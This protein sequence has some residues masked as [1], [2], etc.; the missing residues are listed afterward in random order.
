MGGNIKHHS[1]GSE[2]KEKGVKSGSLRKANT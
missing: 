1:E 2:Q